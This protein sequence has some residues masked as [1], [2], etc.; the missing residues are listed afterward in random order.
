MEESDPMKKLFGFLSS[1]ENRSIE[2]WGAGCLL[3]TF[4]MDLAES[5]PII[6]KKVAEQ[7]DDFT[8]KIATFF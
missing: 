7:F 3:G 8:T 2:F 1:I 6:R 5:N 4:A